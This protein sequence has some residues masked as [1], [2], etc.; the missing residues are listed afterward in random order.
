MPRKPLE[1]VSACGKHDDWKA[2]C[3]KFA[4]LTPYDTVDGNQKSGDITSWGKG[5]N[6]IIYKGYQ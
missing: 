3:S 6:P 1:N 2:G 4:T 5:R